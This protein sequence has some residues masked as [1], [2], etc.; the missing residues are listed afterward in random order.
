MQHNELVYG[1]AMDP[2]GLPATVRDK[3]LARVARAKPAK[4]EAG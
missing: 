1:V 4:V 3:V 2:N